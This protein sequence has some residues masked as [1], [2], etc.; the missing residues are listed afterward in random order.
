MINSNKDIKYIDRDFDTLKNG[1]IEFS[2]TYFPNTYND[3]SPSS[4]GSMFI[5]M[6]S[7]VGDILSFYIDNQ[8]QETFLQYARQEPNLYDL[9]Y[10]MG[11]KPRATGAATVDV[12]F[13]QQL[14]SKQVGGTYVPDFNYALTIKENA[15]LSSNL[16]ESTTFLTQDSID[17]SVSSSSDPTEITV[18]TTSGGDADRFLL[19]KTRKAL[20]AAINTTTFTFGAAEQ[21]P[22]VTLNGQNIIGI[23]DITDSDGNVYT[24]VDYLAQE[25]VFE[26]VKN[27]EAGETTSGPFGPDPNLDGDRS[28]VPFLLRLKKTPRRFVT[29]FKSKTRLDIQFGAGTQND[30]DGEITPDPSF[31]GMGLAYGKDKLTTAFNPANFLYTRTY[32]IAPKNTT[33]T[34][35]YLVG[36]GVT[37]NVPSDVLN[38]LAGTIKFQNVN[39][40]NNALAQSIFDSVIANNPIGASGGDDGD[41]IEELRENSLGSYGAQLR[42][43]TQEDY[44]IRALSLPP[45]FG[46]IAKAFI[47]PQQIASLQPGEQPRTLDLYVSA[48][49]NLNQLTNASTALKQNL[50]TYLSQF[51]TVNDSIRLRDAFI[52]N[53]GV[54][55]DII[56]LPNFN[57]NQVISD[58]ITQLQSY[59]NV[60]NMQVNQP[61]LLKEIFVLL[62]KVNGVQTVSSV[63][64]TNKVGGNYSQYAYD[65]KGANLNNIIYPSVDPSIFEVKFPSTDIRG[66]AIAF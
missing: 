62:D 15:V 43:V 2:K 26:S 18:Y 39:P 10:M 3:F 27:T 60:K 51:R 16:G 19:K 48:Y 36:G 54:D 1:L 57:N 63:D 66:R 59:F 25:M 23:L 37:A 28:S 17:F 55:F 30:G 47:R 41:S 11:Y 58:C 46:T 44:L 42:A 8:V 29:R 33:L 4:P 32:G 5:E 38:T 22:T 21:F 9:A 52:V 40:G 13:F 20:S 12:D 53:I 14:P 35:R 50:A 6:A 7:Y 64:I 49:N 45:E 61:I 34:V 65:I 31:V 56:V 24:E